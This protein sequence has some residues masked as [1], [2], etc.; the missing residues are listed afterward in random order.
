MKQA[1]PAALVTGGCGF[2]GRHVTLRLLADGYDVWIVDDESTGRDPRNW[3]VGA[4]SW[5]ELGQNILR[6]NDETSV[7]Y[8]RA[9]VRDFF[10]QIT[11][12]DNPTLYAGLEI[13]PERFDRAFHFAAVVGGRVKIEGDPLSVALDLA[14]D[15]EFFSWAVKARPGQILYASSS[16]AYPTDLQ[17]E[18]YAIALKESSI[19]FDGTLGVPDMTY[20]WSKLTG[21]YL[22][23]IAA[24]SYG[25][26]IA[27]VRPFSGYGEDQEPDYPIPA[28]A[29]RA[30]NREEPLTIWG[31][32]NQGRDFVHIDDCVDAMFLAAAALPTFRVVLM[33]WDSTAGLVCRVGQRGYV[34]IIAV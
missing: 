4:G 15:A 1:R 12:S 25:L 27:C 31:S 29:G 19:N 21:E 2:V 26:S 20:G 5:E 9:D 22:S 32:G 23:R 28:I 24:S 11:A 33:R 8:I 30:A 6:Y 16:A 10:R 34:A 18:E 3:M 13:M 14:I 7:T 17:G